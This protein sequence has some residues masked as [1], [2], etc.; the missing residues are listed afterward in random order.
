VI[1]FFYSSM[2][3]ARTDKLIGLLALEIEKIKESA[4]KTDE[5][6]NMVTTGL[7]ESGDKYHTQG[8]ADLTKSYLKRLNLLKKELESATKDNSKTAKPPCFLQ[9]S[10]SDGGFTEL[11]LVKNA[12]SLPS[13]SFISSDSP[14]GKAVYGKKA[15]DIFSYSLNDSNNY[16]GK[17][18][19]IE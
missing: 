9:I 1:F 8:A 14:L 15:G 10:F 3:K 4:Q 2:N 16:S 5:A 19:E 12:V 18:V 6:A 11:Y 7:S 17:I 13:I